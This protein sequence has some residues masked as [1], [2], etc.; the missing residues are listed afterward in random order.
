MVYQ[1]PYSPSLHPEA[2]T[3]RQAMVRVS[4]EI[5]AGLCREFE[6]NRWA[7]QWRVAEG[8]PPGARLIRQWIDQD[9]CYL[10]M[11]FEHESFKE[12]KPG[13]ILPEVRPLL[14]TRR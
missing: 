2:P 6:P 5:I 1:Q 12:C 3:S 4:L 9:R 10:V 13:D 7:D 11:V 14:H 8:V